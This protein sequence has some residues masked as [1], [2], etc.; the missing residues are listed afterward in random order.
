MDKK[1]FTLSKFLLKDSRVFRDPIHNY[2]HVNHLLFWQLINTKEIQRLRR[3]KQLGGTFQVYQ[4]AEHSRFTHSLGVY[5]VARK[6]IEETEINQY[7]NDY[8]IATVLCAALTHDLGHGPYSHSFEQ[9][10]HT[11]H[12]SIT[13]DILLGDT[14]VNKVL[15]RYHPDLAK[16]VALV[17]EK[18]H[19]NTVLVQMISSQIDADRMDYLLRDSY[20]TGTTYGQFDLSR[21]LRTLRIENGQIVYKLSGVQAIE[22]YILARY[23]MYWQVYYHP[24]ARSFEQLLA[25]VFYRV[26]DLYQEDFDFET[27]IRYLIPFLENNWDYR[28]Y[29]SL[30][31]AVVQYYFRCFSESKDGILSDLATR[32]LDRHLF[33][34]QD[35]NHP[36]EVFELQQIA[37]LQG[38]D[39]RYYII[40]D[41]Q[42]QIPYTHYGTMGA[43]EDIKILMDKQGTLKDLPEVSEIVD[44]IV[45]SKRNKT[46]QKIYYPKE[47]MHATHK[48]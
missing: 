10:F 40:T 32:F 19:S 39:P 11:H 34:H 22:N 44:A 12:E 21:I 8:D 36:E 18:K 30:D 24:T 2:I 46:D 41:N 38:F 25:K 20:F 17:I 16:D 37:T 23:H 45:K 26:C 33:K 48:E 35:L 28:D 47:M 42:K 9:V 15:T 27:D 31:E 14:D 6:M 1:S 29:L 4:S 3:I 7:L 13:I 5:E 43:I